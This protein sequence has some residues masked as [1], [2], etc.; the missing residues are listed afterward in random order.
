MELYLLVKLIHILSATI[1][2]GTGAGIAFFMWQA[3]RSGNI[4]VMARVARHVVRADLWFTTPAVVIQPLTGFWLMHMLGLPWST[5]WI[6][7]SLVLYLLV[8]CVWIPVVFI[9]MRVA[10]IAARLAETGQPPPESL[11]RAMRWW[12]SL[13]W[14][15]FISVLVIF[16]LMVFKPAF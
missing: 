12:Y 7:V 14:P 16:Y 6:V 9:Q 13:G 8:G 11:K 10:T 3:D 5:P 15:A 2:F 4:T 1:L